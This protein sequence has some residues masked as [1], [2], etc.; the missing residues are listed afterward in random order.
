MIDKGI[1]LAILLPDSIGG[2]W[3]N[4][5]VLLPEID[6]KKTRMKRKMRHAIYDAIYGK[7]F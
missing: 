4:D 7:V 1:E 2:G 6:E 3:S 5:S